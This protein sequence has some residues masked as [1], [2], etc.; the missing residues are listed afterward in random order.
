MTASSSPSNTLPVLVGVGQLTNRHPEPGPQTE[1][2]A[3]MAEVARLAAE[4]A[5]AACRQ[6]RQYRIQISHP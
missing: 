3:Y 4:D 2:L 1:P 5:G 6:W